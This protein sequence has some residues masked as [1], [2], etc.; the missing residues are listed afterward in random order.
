MEFK[1]AG[2][3]CWAMVIDPPKPKPKRVFR[4]VENAGYEGETI[5]PGEFPS[6][7]KAWKRAQRIYRPSEQFEL[8]VDVALQL[9]DGTLTYDH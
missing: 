2:R 3:G 4:I 6:S 5:L 7:D 8:H 1:P 9:A